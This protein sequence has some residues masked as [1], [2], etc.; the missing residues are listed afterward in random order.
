M[1]CDGFESLKEI[2]KQSSGLFGVI[3]AFCTNVEISGTWATLSE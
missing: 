1:G 2:F 3:E